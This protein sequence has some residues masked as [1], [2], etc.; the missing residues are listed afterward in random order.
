MPEAVGWAT[1]VH[2][3]CKKPVSVFSKGL[4]VGNEAQHA[5]TPEKWTIYFIYLFIYY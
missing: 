1:E 2:V 4:V 5:V 3:A